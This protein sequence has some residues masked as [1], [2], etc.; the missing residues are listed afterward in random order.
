[1]TN[2]RRNQVSRTRSRRR[3]TRTPSTTGESTPVLEDQAEVTE[4]DGA[5]YA[6]APDELSAGDD[7]VI[8]RSALQE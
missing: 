4:A 1:M 6:R 5:V 2:R 8:A 7:A 3:F